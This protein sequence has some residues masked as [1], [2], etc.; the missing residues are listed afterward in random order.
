VVLNRFPGKTFEF[1]TGGYQTINFIPSIATMIFGLMCGGLLRSGYKPSRKLL[2][3]WMA[4]LGGLALGQLLNQTGLCPSIK[5][6]WTPSW[7]IFS[8]GWCCLILAMLYL[9]VDLFRL[10]WLAFPLVVVGMN[11]IL[12]YCMSMTLKGFTAKQLQIHFGKDVFTLY[13]HISSL[14]EPTVKAVLVGLVFWLVCFYCYRRKI[15]IAI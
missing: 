10:R 5:R 3:L 4:G 1:N 11:S 6:I 15:F 14:W 13:G 9:V 8:T 7:A 2:I 12:I